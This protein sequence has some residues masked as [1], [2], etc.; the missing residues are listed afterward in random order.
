MEIINPSIN[1]G[2]HV[3]FRADVIN[4][5]YSTGLR[6]FQIFIGSP[7]S[8]IE[9]FNKILDR[10][11]EERKRIPEDANIIVHGKYIYNLVKGN[12]HTQDT[13]ASI[14]KQ[15]I[16][17]FAIKSSIYVTHIGARHSQ[18][19]LNEGTERTKDHAYN[20]WKNSI[21]FLQ[22][23]LHK[24]G[25]KLCFENTPGSKGNTYM[26]SVE[27]I[28]KIVGETQDYSHIGYALDT[29]HAWANGESI[30]KNG[31]ELFLDSVIQRASVIHLNANESK[32]AFGSHRDR[33]SSTKLTESEGLK[34]SILK[35][36]FEIAR[37]P[38]IL[39]RYTTSF[40]LEEIQEL[41]EWSHII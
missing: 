28:L 30:F 19:E 3:P 10:L 22:P 39:E 24:F 18:E 29:Q 25:I 8:S 1:L 36:V 23:T 21:K 4:L 34:V 26:G 17:C 14:A 16:V 7:Q 5:L 2:A 41:K 37:S 15:L 40:I 20:V 11:T 31:K 35:R 38:I 13:L 9:D 27:D 33:H 32:V 12:Q 6:S